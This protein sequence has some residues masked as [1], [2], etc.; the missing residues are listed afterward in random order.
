MSVLKAARSEYPTVFISE[1]HSDGPVS[2]PATVIIKNESEIKMAIIVQSDF[3][4][5]L[6]LP[7]LYRPPTILR[8]WMLLRA[9]VATAVC[10]VRLLSIS[11]LKMRNK[12]KV[13][14]I[15]RVYIH[16]RKDR[17]ALKGV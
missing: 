1:V 4:V 9:I 5:N 17:E 2:L 13:L 8:L 6:I 16:E 15:S 14:G 12:L 10:F 7:P 11:H 3:L